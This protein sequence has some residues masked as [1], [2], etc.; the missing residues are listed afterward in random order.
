MTRPAVIACSGRPGERQVR[1]VLVTLLASLCLGQQMPKTGRSRPQPVDETCRRD[2]SSGS[3]CSASPSLVFSSFRC[4]LPS[5]F[6]FHLPRPSIHPSIHPHSAIL[7]THW[8]VSWPAHH[9]SL[10]SP[11]LLNSPS[12]PHAAG[13]FS[14]HPSPHL[15]ASSITITR[16]SR[17]SPHTHSALNAAA[18]PGIVYANRSRHLPACVCSCAQRTRV[19]HAD[20]AS[21]IKDIFSPLPARSTAGNITFDSTAWCSPHF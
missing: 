21:C 18:T 15:T 4:P 6:I 9:R 19:P 11:P 20:T 14:T 1:V 7:S 3:S 8:P 5:S 17:F 2:S 10:A 13:H 12:F 16:L